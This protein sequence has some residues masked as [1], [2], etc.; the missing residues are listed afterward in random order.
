[1]T[2][3]RPGVRIARMAEGLA[4]MKA[5]WSSPEPVHFKGDHYVIDGAVGTPRP[6]SR[7]HPTVCIGGGGR[8][9]LSLAA[10]EADVVAVNATLTS[11]QLD[12]SVGDTI[13]PAAFDE[14][15]GWVRAATGDRFDAI[16]LQ[17]HCPFVMVTAAREPVDSPL[18]LVGTVEQLCE[19]LQQRRERWGFTYWVVPDDAMEAFAPV[20]A[21]L[22]PSSP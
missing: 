1:M 13:T 6:A 5:L 15:I 3:D 12:A 14:K 16:E 20:V 2:Y 11:G 17:C 8:R 21:R 10:R 7:P 4:V 19:T 18:A 9:I 22:V